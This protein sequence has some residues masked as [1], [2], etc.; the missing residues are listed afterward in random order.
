MGRPR[1]HD[2]AT[3]RDLLRAAEA[4]LA[5]EGIEALSVRR[6]AEAAGTSARA[7]YSRFGSKEG[8]LRAL[9]RD[10]FHALSADL[11]A[12]PLTGDPGRDLIAAGAVGFRGW[13]LSHPDLFR[14]IFEGGAAVVRPEAAD[15]Q[16]GVDAFGRLMARIKRCEEAGQIAVGQAATAGVAFHALC[17]GLASLE[18]RG[19]FPLPGDQT[20]PELWERALAA[21][22]AGFR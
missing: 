5:S 1:L 20:E 10:A 13:A 18:L 17:E 9:F 2:E 19:R 7:I 6:V 3:E 15:S 14:L 16:A 22:V 21:L 8:V 4:L 12:L 11:D